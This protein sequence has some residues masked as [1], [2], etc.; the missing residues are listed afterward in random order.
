MSDFKTVSVVIPAKNEE[1]TL[2]LLLDGLETQTRRPAQIILADANSNDATRD[3]ALARGCT[4]V[5]GGFPGAGRNAGA[6]LATGDWLLFLDADVQLVDPRFIERSLAE[7][8]TRQLDL[9]SPDV[10][11]LG[12][13]WVDQLGH[14]LYNIYVRCW[15]ARRPHAPGFCIFIRRELFAAVGGFDTSITLAED[16]DLAQRAGRRGKFGILKNFGIRVIDRRFRRDGSWRVIGKYILGELHMIFLGPIR[17]ERFNY[18]FGY[19]DHDH[20]TVKK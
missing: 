8:E 1:R 11:L 4:V 13:N 12:G 17:H 15:G 16:H 5:A 2:P 3:L 6:L 7:I 10:I 18:H 19:D 20:S 9:A 14:R